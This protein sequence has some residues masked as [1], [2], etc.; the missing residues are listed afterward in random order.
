MTKVIFKMVKCLPGKVLGVL[1]I[2]DKVGVDLLSVCPQCCQE[3]HSHSSTEGIITD[4]VIN[5]RGREKELGD[6]HAEVGEGNRQSQSKGS[7]GNQVYLVQF[8]SQ[9]RLEQDK[10]Y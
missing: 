1:D 6:E 10:H 2:G 7:G 4:L 9:C 8:S 3:V 5:E